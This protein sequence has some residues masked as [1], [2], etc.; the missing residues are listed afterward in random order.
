MYSYPLSGTNIKVYGGSVGDAN[1]RMAVD[2][3]DYSLVT[4]GTSAD[5]QPSPVWSAGGLEDG[6]HQL[7]VNVTS[8][9]AKALVFLHYF[10]YVITF[11]YS[12]PGIASSRFHRFQG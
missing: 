12:V 8:L 7:F 6:D 11:T 2:G 9:P 4:Q 10:E 5:I 3:Q 1:W